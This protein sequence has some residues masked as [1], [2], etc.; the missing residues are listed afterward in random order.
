MTFTVTLQN[1]ANEEQIPSAQQFQQWINTA[2]ESAN[3]A[4]P[5]NLKEVCVR[6]V[7][8]DESEHLNKTYRKKHGPTNVLSF[9]YEPIPGCED[10]SLGDLAICAALVKEEALAQKKDPIA[11]WAHLSVH[12]TLHLLGFNHEEETEAEAME[13]LE[14][15]ILSTLN[16]PNPY[17]DTQ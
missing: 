17:K 14:A 6:I 11:H 7:S 10:D 4:L 8:K 12:G 2:I 3:T 15:H 5:A 1:V 9:S 16:F 13:T